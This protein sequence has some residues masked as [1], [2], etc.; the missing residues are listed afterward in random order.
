MPC[1]NGDAWFKILKSVQTLRKRWSDL[2]KNQCA[3]CRVSETVRGDEVWELAGPSG[4]VLL[5]SHW[6]TRTFILSKGISL[7]AQATITN[8]RKLR[9]LHNRN[10][11]SHSS[12][13]WKS[14]I[15]VPVWLSFGKSCLPGLQA[16]TC[17]LCLHVARVCAESL[18]SCPTLCDPMDRSPPGSSVHGI[19]QARILEWVAISFSRGSS[20]PR[21][22]IHIS[23]NSCI[24]GG[25]FTAEPLDESFPLAE[26]D[27]ASSGDY[28]D[29]STNPIMR[30]HSFNLLSLMIFLQKAHLQM[31][32]HRELELQCLNFGGYNSVHSR[33]DLP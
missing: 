19:L 28:S 3:W 32:A 29:E 10:L 16:P 7:E 31:P 11:F 33:H 12:A 18:Q 6:M 15:R 14:E 24:A 27:K 17:F 23:R 2:L 30:T 4:E 20:W 26:R 1:W 21:D 8:Y 25:F 13:G 5:V 22:R 9:G